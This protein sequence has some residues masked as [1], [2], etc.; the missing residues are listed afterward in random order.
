MESEVKYDPVPVVRA[1][2]S[3]IN[4]EVVVVPETT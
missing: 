3:K 2:A 1:V 4:A